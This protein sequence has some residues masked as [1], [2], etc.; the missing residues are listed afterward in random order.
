MIFDGTFFV[1][2][3]YNLKSIRSHTRPHHARITHT[4]H[5]IV[6]V[7]LSVKVCDIHHFVLTTNSKGKTE[8]NRY[9]N[10]ASQQCYVDIHVNYTHTSHIRAQERTISAIR[11]ICVYVNRVRLITHVSLSLS[12][13]YI[14]YPY[15]SNTVSQTNAD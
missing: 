10:F 11:I 14:Q 12:T 5:G 2:L 6:C 4:V 1:S 13:I 7:C 15:D 9:A 8:K 3:C